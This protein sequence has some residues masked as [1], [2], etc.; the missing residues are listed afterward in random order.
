MRG[1][2]FF[3]TNN[4]GPARAGLFCREEGAEEAFGAGK[5]IIICLER[6]TRQKNVD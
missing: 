5:G 2:I 3:P 1:R 6:D 4:Q